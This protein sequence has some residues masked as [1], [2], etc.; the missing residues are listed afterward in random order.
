VTDSYFLLA[1]WLTTYISAIVAALPSR[2]QQALGE[3]REVLEAMAARNADATES[4]MRHH[5]AMPGSV[6]SPRSQL[7]AREWRPRHPDAEALLAAG[8]GI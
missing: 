6:L 7:Q 5:I 4:T 1:L 2:A 8:R 3:H